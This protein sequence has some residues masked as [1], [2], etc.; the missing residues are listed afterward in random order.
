MIDIQTSQE[1]D[2][3]F[4]HEGMVKGHGKGVRSDPSGTAGQ[5]AV[6]GEHA[7]N[8]NRTGRLMKAREVIRRITLPLPG[9][10]TSR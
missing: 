10:A 6:D 5:T 3:Q 4:A 9:R 8:P 1:H 7:T 2:V